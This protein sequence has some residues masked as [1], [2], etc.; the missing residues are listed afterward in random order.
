MLAKYIFIL[1]KHWVDYPR[2][3]ENLWP[4]GQG[5]ARQAG[6]S[7]HNSKRE[8]ILPVSLVSLLR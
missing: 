1:Q 8:G 2:S 5:F 6:N 4:I 7:F 3:I